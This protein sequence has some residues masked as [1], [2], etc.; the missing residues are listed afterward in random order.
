MIPGFEE[1]MKAYGEMIRNAKRVISDANDIIGYAEMVKANAR[2]SMEAL[3]DEKE[4]LEEV[5]E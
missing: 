1:S 4:K 3:E 5:E 2:L